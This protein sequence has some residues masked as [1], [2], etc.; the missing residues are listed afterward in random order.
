M[1]IELSAFTPDSSNIKFIEYVSSKDVILKKDD[2]GLLRIEFNSGSV[3]VYEEVPFRVAVDLLYAES[4]GEKFNST[5]RNSNY[6]YR[7]ET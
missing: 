4:V 2:R 3:Y 1:K 5:I 6:V 7:K